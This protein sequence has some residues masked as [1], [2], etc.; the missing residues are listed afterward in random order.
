MTSQYKTW[1]LMPWFFNGSLKMPNYSSSSSLIRLLTSMPIG[2]RSFDICHHASLHG[3]THSLAHIYTHAL[4]YTHMHALTPSKSILHICIRSR[5]IFK[6]IWDFV[7]DHNHHH[8]RPD[9]LFDFNR[10]WL[11]KLTKEDWKRTELQYQEPK[12]L[13]GRWQYY[14]RLSKLKS[15]ELKCK[16]LFSSS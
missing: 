2:I 4:T 13:N 11:R 15:I 5:L 6:V 14:V 16:I 9:C 7:H 10:K 8:L 12:S 1:A 3:H